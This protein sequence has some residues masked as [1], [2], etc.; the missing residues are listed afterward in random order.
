MVILNSHNSWA[1]WCCSEQD[2][3]GL[4]WT[5]SYPQ[6]MWLQALAAIAE[7]YATNPR[8]VGLDLR[9]EL[10]RAHSHSPVWGG[11]GQYDWALAAE[12]AGNLVLDI[13]PGL[14]VIVEGLEYA[15]STVEGARERPLQVRLSCIHSVGTQL[16]PSLFP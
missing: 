6:E 3:E 2:G 7:N 9:N 12:T 8:V 15:G 11:G 4:W 16:F 13:N 10:R 14:L 5:A 1:D